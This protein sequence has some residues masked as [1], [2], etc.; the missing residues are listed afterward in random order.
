MVVL[1]SSTAALLVAA[2]ALLVFQIATFRKNFI[3]DLELLSESI[4][5]QTRA[6]VAFGYQSEAGEVLQS[7]RARPNI[8][9][10]LIQLHDGSVFAQYG[11]SP[12]RSLLGEAK[13]RRFRLQDGLVI[14]ATPVA[15]G[16]AQ[17]GTLYVQSEY[18]RPFRQLIR[19]YLGILGIVFAG[20]IFLTLVLS[21]RLQRVIS[22]PILRLAETAKSIAQ[23][24]D[25]SAR[26]P[27][28]EEDELGTL[29][30]AF[31]Q[32]LGQIQL[33]DSALVKAH[34]EL[35]Q[36]V[37]A[38]QREIAERKRA[39]QQL[40]NVHRELMETSRQA[41]MAEVATGVLHNVGNV[42]NSVNVSST[43]LRE[44][45][46][47]SEVPSM[48]KLAELF[49][50][51]GDKL[52]AYLTSDP[53]GKVIPQ[54]VTALAEQLVIEREILLKEL[55]LL[56]KNVEHIKEIVTM[57]QSYAKSSG[58]RQ[59]VSLEELVE[60][61][62]QFN[63]AALE[64]H[65][66]TVTREYEPVPRVLLDKHKVLQIL[67][68]LIHNAKYALQDVGCGEKQL[69][70]SIQR[71]GDRSIAI[72]VCD[73]GIGIAPENLTRIFAHG[74]TTRKEGH[75]FGLHSSALAARQMGGELR[76]ASAGIGHGAAFTL[77]IPLENPLLEARAP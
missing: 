10:A 50:N 26:A 67:V 14:L 29:T 76:A 38:L 13:G 25:Y 21:H 27:K 2:A 43:L 12:A 11:E 1:L 73:N 18:S 4:V 47:K 62:L 32:M 34:G 24:G 35:E 54:F 9:A 8:R 59:E 17:L 48:Q 46:R 52:A 30:D 75:G 45:V 69:R 51:Q 44:Q 3:R 74:Y 56:G 23:Q 58:F 19:V 5:Q 20:S 22:E 6:M 42:L 57:Q 77:E 41:G 37:Q 33:Q 39:E 31:N 66:I 36:R 40:E 15:R 28:M 49:R 63:M 60:D 72:A 65:Q 16:E 71:K 61:A 53:R 70:I 68:N 7:L 55:E 64:R